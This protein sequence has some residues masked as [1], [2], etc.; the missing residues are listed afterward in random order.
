MNLPRMTP[1]QMFWAG[2]VLV[3]G[4]FLVE[5]VLQLAVSGM[6]L[7][8][9]SGVVAVVGVVA[10]LT[11]LVRQLGVALV[12]GALVVRALR[13]GHEPTVPSAQGDEA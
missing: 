4:G 10:S 3:V 6:Y 7:P 5:A 13:R 1:V 11:S 2:V 12:V 8:P 9:G